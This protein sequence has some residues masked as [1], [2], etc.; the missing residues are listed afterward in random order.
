MMVGYL[1]MIVPTILLD[2]EVSGGSSI[3][4]PEWMLLGTFG[5]M[6]LFGVGMFFSLLLWVILPPAMSHAAAQN[7][8]SAGFHIREWWKI[9][10][11]NLGGFF[12]SIVIAGG[13][14]MVMIFAIQVL[15]LTIILCILVPFLMMFVMTYLTI[16][17]LALFAQ[18]YKDGQDKLAAQPVA[19][20]S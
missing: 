2:P 3:I 12:L 20:P 6:A 18:A 4:A 1:M 8:F 19:L 15:Y 5:G 14:Y 11:A 10:R 13:L 16:V 17:A 9:Y 7:S